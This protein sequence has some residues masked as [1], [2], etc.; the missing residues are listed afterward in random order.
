VSSSGLFGAAARQAQVAE[1][2]SSRPWPLPD[3]PWAQAQTREDV[4][5]AHWPLAPVELGRL[6]PPELAVDTFDGE[7]WL[8]IVPFR[9]TNLR[10][11]GLPPVPGF[12]SFLQLDILTY[13]IHD[14][15]PGIWLFSLDTTNQLLVEAARRIHR[16]PAYRARIS[17]GPGGRG[18]RFEAVRDGLAFRVSYAGTGEPF[19]A[20]LGT[21]EHFLTERYCLYTADGGRLYRADLHH[22]PWRLQAAVGE[23][24]ETTLA[25][26]ALEGEPGL[27]FA[28][29]QDVLV[30]PLEEV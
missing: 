4:L 6:L 14:G 21:H 20:A 2:V 5:F 25:P 7:A 26:I 13:V 16:L 9:L 17:A 11:R 15:R 18:S 27:L 30:W 10:L 19:V 24:E 28:A 1:D 3:G 23:V 12:S 8:G 22:G 29:A